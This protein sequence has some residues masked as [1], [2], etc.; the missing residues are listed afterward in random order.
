V[1]E[2]IAEHFALDLRSIAGSIVDSQ[3][4]LSSQFGKQAYPRNLF[5]VMLPHTK[6]EMENKTSH[7]LLKGGTLLIHDEHDRVIPRKLDLLIQDD[8][9]VRIDHDIQPPTGTKTIDCVCTLVSPGFIDT[10]RHLWQSQQKGL[11]C[12][13]ILLDYYHSGTIKCQAPLFFFSDLTN[14]KGISL[15][16]IMSQ[17]MSSAVS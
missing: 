10:H 17:M 14:K 9:I 3:L 12:D 4:Q 1:P 6:K 2:T 5:E 7:I 8:R 11:H 13:Q 16:H 15:A